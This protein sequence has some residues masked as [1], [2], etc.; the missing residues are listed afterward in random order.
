MRATDAYSELLA[1]G[2]PVIETKEAAARLGVNSNTAG[3]ILRTIERAGLARQVHKGLWTLDPDITP[4]VLATY[5][6]APY[7]AY[8][9][10]WSAFARHDMIEQIPTRTE[11]ASL[12]RARTLDTPLGSFAIHRLAPEV[13]TGFEGTPRSGYFA[14]PE[15]AL[16][17]VVYVRAPRGAVVRFPELTLPQ[18]LDRQLLNE[19]AARIPRPRLRT[20]VTKGLQ[21]ALDQADRLAAAER[22]E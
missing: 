11:I 13:F 12:G 16:F 7:P 9:S 14:R 22:E 5:L 8:V 6:T 4:A 15:K 21:A 17:D 20:I 18:D 10:F 1:I 3:K 19:W 2:R